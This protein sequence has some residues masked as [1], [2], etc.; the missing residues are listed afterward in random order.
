[1]MKK[2]LI[3]SYENPYT[4]FAGDEIYTCNLL[5]AFYALGWAVSFL[6]YNSNESAPLLPEHQASRMAKH[7]VIPFTP[8]S[9]LS[10]ALSLQPGMIVN[11]RRANYKAVF[12]Q[13]L[14][15]EQYDLVVLN[16]QKMTFLA[17]ELTIAPPVLYFSH[18]AEYLLSRNT[19]LQ[20]PNGLQKWLYAQ[21]ALKTRRFERKMLKHVQAVTA[22]C[23]HD[24]QYFQ[25]FC[26]KTR[27]LRPVLESPKVLKATEWDSEPLQMLIVGS[28]TWGPKTQNLL[29]F[30]AAY[31]EEDLAGKGIVLYVVGK[32]AD[33]VKRTI[34]KHYPQ[35]IV[36]G[37]VASI[38]AYYERCTI[39]VV[40]EVL[41]GGFK[42]KVVEAAL[43]G[44]AIVAIKGAI[45][46]SNFKPGFHYHESAN[47]SQMATDILSIKSRKEYLRQ[48]GMNA[49][50]LSQTQYNQQVFNEEL[51]N[52]LGTL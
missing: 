40:P 52:I 3:A 29:Q 37:R 5:E 4:R 51:K 13:W 48:L 6:Y 14:A 47:F 18:N 1:M 23:E 17:L 39:A 32:M 36:T 33:G 31:Q 43:R 9:K 7:Q 8:A 38:E 30:L 45:V 44:K 42:L 49:L 12:A 15:Q 16:H 41:G 2:V 21:D 27:V 20:F 28:F 35:V 19:F 34:A 26:P 11:R 25:E 24:E 22:I 10:L 46:E 50:E